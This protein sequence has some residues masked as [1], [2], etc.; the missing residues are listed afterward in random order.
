MLGQWLVNFATYKDFQ[1]DVSKKSKFDD[2]SIIN[3]N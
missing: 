1:L 2:P 3:Y